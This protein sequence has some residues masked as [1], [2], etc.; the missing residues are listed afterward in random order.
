VYR[1]VHESDR[2]THRREATATAKASVNLNLPQSANPD[3]I[4]QSP[5]IRLLES[6]LQQGNND[7]EVGI[8]DF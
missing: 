2:Q 3:S 5:S 4:R 1:L 6:Q 8:T 7:A